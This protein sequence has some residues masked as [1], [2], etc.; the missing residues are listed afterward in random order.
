MWKTILVSAAIMAACSAYAALDVNQASVADLDGIKGIGPSVSS[1]IL[2]ERK[3]GPFKDWPDLI[4]RVKGIGSGNAQRFSSEGLTVN[5]A[6]FDM[7]PGK[8]PSQTA[9]TTAVPATKLK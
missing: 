2:D 9:K 3:K 5:G 1:R 6:T 4:G 8:T 7:A